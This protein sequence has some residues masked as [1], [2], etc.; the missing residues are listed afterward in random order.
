[1]N[2]P[3]ESGRSRTSQ[4]KLILEHVKIQRIMKKNTSKSERFLS[5]QDATQKERHPD[6]AICRWAK[7]RLRGGR[8]C[9]KHIYGINSHRCLQMTPVPDFCTFSCDFCWRKFGKERFKQKKKWPDAKTLV[10]EM[11]EKQRKLI[12]GFGGS[13]YV[14][15]ERWKEAMRPAHFAISLDG[16]PTLYPYLGELIKEIKLRGMSAFLV[17]NGT[18]PFRLKKLLEMRAI[19][20]NLS[21]SVYATNAED[22]ERIV[23]PFIKEA[24]GRIIES[25]KLMRRFKGARTNFRMTL[26]KGL[27]LK[28]AESYA[29]LIR[30]AKPKFVTVK[31]YS[32]LGASQERL[33]KENMPRMEELE[34]F[35][36]RIAELTGYGIK[37]KDKISTVIVLVRDEKVWEWNDKKIREQRK[38]FAEAS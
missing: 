2:K 38:R 25:L 13:Q 28:D 11:I 29:G 35:A 20:D 24:F 9:Y 33:R 1:M 16:E 18:M 31:G 6:V 10:D 34:E 12:S 19:P 21:I 5:S 17:T 36:E 23:N 37:V 30:M 22:Y 8:N 32:F 26:V 15:R 27:N 7:T 3:N 4:R 14:T